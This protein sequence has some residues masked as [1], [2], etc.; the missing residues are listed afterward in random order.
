MLVKEIMHFEDLAA[1][2]AFRHHG[3]DWQ[4]DR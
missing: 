2:R 4:I 3:S 1:R